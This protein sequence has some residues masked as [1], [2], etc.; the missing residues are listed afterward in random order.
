[1]I[2]FRI[3]LGRKYGLGHYSRIKSLINY[4]NIKKYKIVID[5]QSDKKFLLSKKDEIVSLYSHNE[6]FKNEMHDA[7][8]FLK[9]LKDNHKKLIIIKDSYRMGYNW[10]K[11]VSRSCKKV[12]SIDDSLNNKHFSDIYINHN[13]GISKNDKTLLINLKKKNKKNCKFLLGPDFALFNSKYKKKKRISSDLVFYNGGSGDLSIY[14]KIIKKLKKIKKNFKISIIIGPYSKNQKFISKFKNFSKIKLVKKQTNICEI[15]K[16]TR[17]FIS[18]ASISMFESSFLKIP[19]LL[20]K[21][22]DKQNL[23]DLSYEKLGHYFSLRKNDIKYT[24]KIANLIY[25][26]FNNSSQIKKTMS[27]SNLNIKKIQIN[28]RKNLKF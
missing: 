6:T 27:Q 11:L 8:K 2:I 18:P 19:T 5:K 4:L 1:M 14:E 23:P 17:L 7:K 16:G 25:L 3:D 26:M 28:Y 21:M 24:D 10:E 9:L 22:N 13:P 12:I 15:L 20:I